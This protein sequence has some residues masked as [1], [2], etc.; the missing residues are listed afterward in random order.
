MI[1][2]ESSALRAQ[3]GEKATIHNSGA[4]DVDNQGTAIFAEAGGKAISHVDVR[5]EGA[6]LLNEKSRN[7]YGIQTDVDA[8]A[9]A[10]GGDFTLS[11]IVNTAAITSLGTNNGGI[12]AIFNGS[13]GDISNSGDI[14]VQRSAISTLTGGASG[15]GGDLAIDSSGKLT[16]T[17]EHGIW[18]YAGGPGN[19]FVSNS[20]SIEAA[21]T[22][23][24]AKADQ[25]R[26]AVLNSG[27]VELG[28]KATSYG[29]TKGAIVVNAQ[30]SLIT[31]EGAIHMTGSARY[32]GLVALAG[33][34]NAAASVDNHG[35]ISMGSVTGQSHR[36]RRRR[37]CEC[38]QLC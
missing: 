19:V 2:G 5:N 37:Q 35:A 36:V 17:G 21:L 4:I 9:P 3:S 18:A 25:G 7:G 28:Q 10:E 6:I 20:G 11:T 27:D 32:D 34:P 24:T 33:G 26:A 12:S 29:T 23:I 13:R 1:D 22:G 16:S 8:M 31:N 14:A 30:Q 15:L 38:R